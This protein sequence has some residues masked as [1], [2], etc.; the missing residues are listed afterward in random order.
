MRVELFTVWRASPADLVYLVGGWGRDKI[1]SILTNVAF[2]VTTKPNSG[3][4]IYSFKIA[5]RIKGDNT[6]C[7]AVCLAL[8][9][10]AII[11]FP[12]S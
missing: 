4:F 11:L 12:E 1:L 5:L 7:L 10:K 3:G 8:S 9:K 2:S 6:R